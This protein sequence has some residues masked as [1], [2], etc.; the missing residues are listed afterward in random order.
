VALSVFAA[1]APSWSPDGGRLV[2]VGGRNRIGEPDITG[3]DE[4]YVA[5]ANGSGVHRLTSG[6]VHIGA[7]AWSG[8]GKRIVFVRSAAKGNASSLWM[9]DAGGGRLQRLTFGSLDLEPSWAPNGR[10][11]AFLRI[12]PKTYE[13]GI[14]VIHPDG[15]GLHRILPSLRNVT[16]PVWSPGG[17]RLLI[18][19]GHAIYSVRADGSDRRLVTR[20]SS[21]AK[22]ALEDPQ[23]AW[24]PDGK[25]VVF[26]QLRPGSM[27]DS[28]IWVVGANGRGLRRL[29]RSPQLDTDPS[30]AP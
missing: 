8:D 14:W 2:F 4:L 10:E 7:A 24:S 25:W 12:N 29:T 6:T 28:D 9:V 3:P 27:G 19:N 23:P 17:S 26:C 11:I 1:E 20:L 5:N 13:S 21:D 22:G 30:W 15:S 18:E 16:D